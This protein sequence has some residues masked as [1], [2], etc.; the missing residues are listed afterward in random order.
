[1]TEQFLAYYRVSTQR[2]GRS[3]LGLEAQ[4]A[5]VARFLE[6]VPGASLLGEV[7][8]VQSGKE[9]R[10]RPLLLGALDRCRTT[11]ATLVVAK[12]CRLSRDAAFVLTLMK[13]SKVRF[14]VASMPAADNFQ[15]GIWAVLNQQERE[16]ISKRTREALAAAK[17]RG[18]R[19]GGAG[20]AHEAI[21]AMNEANT[22]K[23][24]DHA[25][26]VG[27]LVLTLRNQGQTYREIAKTLN[28]AGIPTREGA[29]WFPS[30]VRRVVL[31]CSLAATA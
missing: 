19:L 21:R 29:L 28:S 30:Q 24:K 5:E 10:N 23:A 15:L 13:D 14:R 1:M 3:G 12:L 11:G 6:G 8:E 2:Q 20:G 18:V 7:T 26:E 25:K 17:A 31:R 9:E 4:R 22:R 16:Q 27:P